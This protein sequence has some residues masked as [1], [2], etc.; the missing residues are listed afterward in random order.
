MN[1]LNNHSIIGGKKMSNKLLTINLRFSKQLRIDQVLKIN[2]V[3]KSY[4]G[5]IYLLTKN[6]NVV[7]ATKFPSLITYLLTINT[8]QALNLLI[9]GPFPKHQLDKI[10]E[11]TSSTTIRKRELGLHPAMKV[12]L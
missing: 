10:E 7:D 3:A 8:G 5:K 12:K 1:N 4:K 6:K 11:I 2:Q 9:D